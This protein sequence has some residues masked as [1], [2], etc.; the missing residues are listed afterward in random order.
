MDLEG[1]ITASANDAA[2]KQR[3]LEDHRREFEQA[4]KTSHDDLQELRKT[5][6][7]FQSENITLRQ[8][9]REVQDETLKVQHEDEAR[10][11]DAQALCDHP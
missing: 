5:N 2:M 7:H 9:Y 1:Q 6:Q 4:L 3:F 10:R 8:E 11:A